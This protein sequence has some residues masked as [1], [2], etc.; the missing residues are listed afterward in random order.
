M[1]KKAKAIIQKS[2]NEYIKKRDSK[3]KVKPLNKIRLLN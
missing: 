2:V 3:K 1:N